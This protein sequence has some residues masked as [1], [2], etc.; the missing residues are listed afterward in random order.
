[1]LLVMAMLWMQQAGL[2]H[3]LEHALEDANQA[4]HVLCQECLSHHGAQAALAST[5]PALHLHLARHAL[6]SLTA[7]TLRSVPLERAYW[8]RAPPSLSV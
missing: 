7:P 2:R 4:A 6:V 3:D 5:P 8:S 1:M